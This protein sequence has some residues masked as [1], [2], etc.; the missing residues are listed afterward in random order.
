LIAGVGLFGVLT[1]SVLQR[2]REIGVRTS[3]GATPWDI[4]RLVLRQALTVTIAGLA[5]GLAA[6]AAL[7]RYLSGLLYGVRG[8]DEVSFAVVPVLLTIVAALA[9]VVPA[10]RAAAVD[11][12]RVLR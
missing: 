6:S 9:C 1:Y 12:V 7:M 10:R 4:V 11:P 3:L 8:F 5:V 2:S